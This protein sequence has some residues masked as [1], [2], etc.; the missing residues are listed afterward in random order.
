VGA[1]LDGEG[2][3]HGSGS[4][5]KLAGDLAPAEAIPAERRNLSEHDPRESNGFPGFRSGDIL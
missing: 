1:I 5:A 4:D 3:A 2:S